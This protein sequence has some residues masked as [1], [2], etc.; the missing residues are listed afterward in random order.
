[1]N[2]PQGWNLKNYVEKGISK[3]AGIEAN[4]KEDKKVKETKELAEEQII[5]DPTS[6][7]RKHIEMTKEAPKSVVEKPLPDYASSFA[8]FFVSEH[9]PYVNTS[10][11]DTAVPK[12][13]EEEKDEILVPK[14]EEKGWGFSFL[15]LFKRK[16]KNIKSNVIWM[17]ISSMI[18]RPNDG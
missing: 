4:F 12:S 16:E 5:N 15:N 7:F 1:M 8:D 3:I 14:K 6:V 9:V 17:L 18:L 13:L 2:I 11:D 10:Y